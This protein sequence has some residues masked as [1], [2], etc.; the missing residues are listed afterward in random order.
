MPC[1]DSTTKALW[2]I[3]RGN[4]Q[5]LSHH[6]IFP[7]SLRIKVTNKSTNYPRF[8]TQF[9]IQHNDSD[10]SE[11]DA[12]YADPAAHP[13]DTLTQLSDNKIESDTKMKLENE[14]QPDNIA[15]T[16]SIA[17]TSSTAAI[18]HTP[19][20]STSPIGS[21]QLRHM[22]IVVDSFAKG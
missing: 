11:D 17:T 12:D 2:S 14:T 7:Y 20:T 19:I 5:P 6:R 21:D 9:H 1:T 8:Q 18:N 3:N 4:P 13:L 15:A 10:L 16:Y 22:D